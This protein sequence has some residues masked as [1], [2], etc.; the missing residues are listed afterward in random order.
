MALG[1]LVNSSLVA[2]LL[3]AT[4]SICHLNSDTLLGNLTPNVLSMLDTYPHIYK[5][6]D[7]IIY[8]ALC[9]LLLVETRVPTLIRHTT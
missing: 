8:V 9:F 7:S 3:N 2:Y 4:L 5:A 6:T 1:V